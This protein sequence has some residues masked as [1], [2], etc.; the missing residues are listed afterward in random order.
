MHKFSIHNLMNYRSRDRIIFSSDKVTMN[1]SIL[2]IFIKI[3][4]KYMNFVLKMVFD[5]KC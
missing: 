4:R 5:N 3:N 1:F 2:Q